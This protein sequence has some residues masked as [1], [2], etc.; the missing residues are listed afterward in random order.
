MKL[1]AGFTYDTAAGTK[2]V[3]SIEVA[4]SGAL[5]GLMKNNL[6]TSDEDIAKMLYQQFN[7]SDVSTLARKAKTS[8]E[9]DQA[10]ADRVG[11]IG[12]TVETGI[13]KAQAMSADDKAK[14]KML[15]EAGISAEELA[16][17]IAARK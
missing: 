7:I 12:A 8:A 14:A 4:D 6:G 17:I 16:K 1:S 3:H 2:T 13:A 15:A 5:I 9:A 11:K 10:I